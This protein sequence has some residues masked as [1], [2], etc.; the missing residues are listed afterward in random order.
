MKKRLDE[1][2]NIALTSK[3]SGDKETAIYSFGVMKSIQAAL[4]ENNIDDFDMPPVPK[5]VEQKVVTPKPSPVEQK[6]PQVQV[7]III[8][9]NFKGRYYSNI[10]T[11]MYTFFGAFLDIYCISNKLCV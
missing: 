11:C 4:A 10:Y 9:V 1:Y 6:S 8:E 3:K 5:K 7:F 2:K